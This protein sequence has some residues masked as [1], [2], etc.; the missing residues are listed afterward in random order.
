MKCAITPPDARGDHHQPHAPS[1]QTLKRIWA[2]VLLKTTPMIQHR[3][4]KEV[5][6]ALK[7]RQRLIGRVHWKDRSAFFLPVE[8]RKARKSVKELLLLRTLFSCK[9]AQVALSSAYQ[10][11]CSAKLQHRFKVQ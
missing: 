1:Y 7:K 6:R 5:V 4:T 9:I 8:V 11:L 2:P 3:L 10:S